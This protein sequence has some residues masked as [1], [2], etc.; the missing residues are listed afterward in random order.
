M[1]APIISTNMFKRQ[2][3]HKQQP[4]VG[5]KIKGTHRRLLF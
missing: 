3:F 2:I 1:I 5:T 4:P